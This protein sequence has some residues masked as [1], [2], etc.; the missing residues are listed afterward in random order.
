M[1]S[2][3]VDLRPRPAP[4]NDPLDQVLAHFSGRTIGLIK[5][6]FRTERVCIHINPGALAFP[7]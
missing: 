1:G 2:G 4:Q 7:S 5:S 3:A 6:G